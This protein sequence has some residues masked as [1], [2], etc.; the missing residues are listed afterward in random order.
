MPGAGAGE[1][2]GRLRSRILEQVAAA[3]RPHTNDRMSALPTGG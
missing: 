3:Q 2:F 1:M